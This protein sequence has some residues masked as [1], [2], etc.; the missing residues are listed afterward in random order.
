MKAHLTVVL[1]TTVFFTVIEGP[2]TAFELTE[3][4]YRAQAEWR[5]M[6]DDLISKGE[7]EVTTYPNP[8]GND[9]P[10]YIF[11]GEHVKDMLL[12][13]ALKML[14]NWNIVAQDQKHN[15]F[16]LNIGGDDYI[17][18]LQ[19]DRNDQIMVYDKN[20]IPPVYDDMF[21]YF[22]S[23]EVLKITHQD[24]IARQM[25]EATRQKLG[26]QTPFSFKNAEKLKK[27]MRDLM[28]VGQIAEPATMKEEM[29]NFL[30]EQY[31][32]IEEYRFETEA[33]YW[34]KASD[35]RFNQENREIYD[36]SENYKELFDLSEELRQASPD[37]VDELKDKISKAL[38]EPSEAFYE[39]LKDAK[40][41]EEIEEVVE[42]LGVEELTDAQYDEIKEAVDI[43]SSDTASDEEIANAKKQ[44]VNNLPELTEEYY[45]EL[46]TSSE[47]NARKAEFAAR[48][49]W[50]KLVVDT[51]MKDGEKIKKSGRVP[52]QD[53]IFRQTID[54]IA[55]NPKLS[56]KEAFTEIFPIH[57]KGG[58]AKA[59]KRL[60][61]EDY[62]LG[63]EVNEED[64]RRKKFKD[65]KAAA[66]GKGDTDT[67]DD[68]IA[69]ASGGCGV[70]SQQT[71]SRTCE[72]KQ[73][74]LIEDSFDWEDDILT[75]ETI[76]EDGIRVKNEI[77]LKMEDMSLPKYAKESLASLEEMGVK[78]EDSSPTPPEGGGSDVVNKGMGIYGSFVSLLSSAKFLQKGDYGQAAFSALQAVYSLGGLTGFNKVIEEVSSKAFAKM[79]GYTADKIGVEKAMEKMMELATKAV[80]ETAARVLDR[81]AGTLP[82]IGIAFD[83]Y[84]VAEDI[85]DLADKNSDTPFGLKIAHLVLDTAIM[86]LSVVESLV[87]EAAPFTEPFIIALTM[88]RIGIDDFYMDIKQ[89]LSQA[90]GK[91]FGDK[92]LA[93]FKGYEEGIVDVFTLG[94][95]TQ[96]ES[97]EQQVAFDQELLNNMTDPEKYFNYRFNN[98]QGDLDFTSGVVSQYGGF[99]NVKMHNNGSV[100]MIM[101]EVPNEDGL[102]ETIVKTFDFPYPVGDIVLGV[103]EVDLPV[104]MQETAYLWMFIPI[105]SDDVIADLDQH[106]SS[107]YGVYTGD[108]RN[109]TFYAL[110]FQPDP[111]PIIIKNRALASAKHSLD[112]DKQKAVERNAGFEEVF[113]QAFNQPSPWKNIVKRSRKLSQLS[114]YTSMD[115]KSLLTASQYNS[116]EC[117]DPNASSNISIYLKSYN[118]NLYG[119]GGDDKFFL[120]PQQTVVSGGEGEDLYYIQPT[121]GKTIID[122]FAIDE[123]IDTLYF[124]VSYDSIRCTRDNW[125]LL[126]GFC[127]THNVR[128]K[129]WFNHENDEF[130][131]HIQMVSK[132]GILMEPTSAEVDGD[133]YSISCDAVVVDRTGSTEGQTLILTGRFE[134]VKDVYGSNYSDTIIGNGLGNL[135]NAGMGDDKLEGGGGK[136]VYIIDEKDGNDI[137]NNFASDYE[138]DT[139]VFSV[140]YIRIKSEIDGSDLILSDSSTPSHSLRLDRWFSN[141]V[142]QHAVFLSKD[143]VQFTVELD[144]SGDPLLVAL[145]IDLGDYDKPVVIDLNNSRN[146]YNYEISQETS[147]D[148]KVIF[149]SKFDDRLV[150]NA[151]GNFFTCTGGNDMLRGNAGKDTYVA[152]TECSSMTID[153]YDDIKDIDLLLIRCQHEQLSLYNA[154]N[155]NKLIVEC[156]K[157]G[158]YFQ[159]IELINWFGGPNYQH[160]FIKTDDLITSFPP[161]N[162]TEYENWNGKLIP[163]E[164]QRKDQC[165]D[166]EIVEINLSLPDYNRVERVEIANDTCSYVIR[167]NAKSNYIDPGPG[168]P[169]H[170]QNLEG[171]NG[172]DVY[173]LGHRYGILN[174]IYNFAEDNQTDHLKFQVIYDDIVVQREEDDIVISSKSM[175]DSIQAVVI[176]YFKGSL[177]QHIVVETADNYMFRF[178]AEFPYTEVIMIDLSSSEYS[179]TISPH[180]NTTFKDAIILIGS[181]T[182]S[183]HIVGG[184]YSEIIIAGNASDTIYGGP[185]VEDLVGAES[186]D[187]IRGGDGD[188]G[189]Y[190]GDGEDLLFG[191]EGD[192]SFFGDL[193]SDV[194]DGG[195]GS[196]FIVFSGVNR[197]GV[198]VTL[199][200]GI[201]L[202]A[203]ATD[204]IYKSIEN[205]LGSEFDDILI[206]NDDNNIIRGYAGRDTLFPYGGFDLLHGGVGSD[207]Y[208]LEEASGPK[209]INNF[210]TDEALDM[211]SLKNYTSDRMCFFYLEEDLIMDISFNVN[212]Q[213]SIGRVMAAENF[214][215][216]TV[217][218]ALKNTTYQHL[219]FFFSDIHMYIEE[220]VEE[221]NQ[222]GAIYNQVYGG[223]FLH[224]NCTDESQICVQVNFTVIEI[225]D[226]PPEKY[227]LEL[228]QVGNNK[229]TYYPLSYIYT[230]GLE[231][232]VLK[233]LPSG[234]EQTFFASLSSCGLSVTYS[235]LISAVTIPNPPVNLIVD[236]VAFDGFT[237]HWEPPSIDTDPLIGNYSYVVKVILEETN[238]YSEHETEDISF[239]TS[240]VLPQ[241]EYK[242]LVY[243]KSYNTSSRHAA[244]LHLTTDNHTCNNLGDLPENLYILNFDRNEDDKLIANLSCIKGYRLHGDPIVICDEPNTVFPTCESLACYIPTLGNA[245][246]LTEDFDNDTNRP[247][248]GNLLEWKCNS[249]FEV[250]INVTTF[251]STCMDHSWKPSPAKCKLKLKCVVYPPQDGS[252]STD[253]IYVGENVTY[254]CNHGYA[255]VGPMTR[256]CARTYYGNIYWIPSYIPTCEHTH[257]PSLVPQAH[258]SYSKPPPYYE[259]TVVVLK[260]NFGYMVSNRYYYP[261]LGEYM[262]VNENWNNTVYLCQS[263]VVTDSFIIEK[264]QALQAKFRWSFTAWNGV[265]MGTNYY[266]H[267]CRQIGGIDFHFILP[268]GMVQC[269]RSFH[270]ENGPS[271]YE[272]ILAVGDQERFG[273]VSYVCI[274]STSVAEEI[275]DALGHSS[276][277]AS[278]YRSTA[279]STSKTLVGNSIN[280]NLTNTAKS[281]TERISCRARCD[282]LYLLNGE[283][284]CNQDRPM[285][286]DKCTFACKN[287]YYLI[288][289]KERQC[290]ANGWTGTHTFC[291]GKSAYF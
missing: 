56:F 18:R 213:D 23:S 37:E 156:V 193:G 162:K 202:N 214:L 184:F 82:F 16:Q 181:K 260:C 152:D 121:G 207:L 284:N 153:N 2:L 226:A 96:L 278:I 73:M 109:N 123:G 50:E 196:D 281:C 115:Q 275:C 13:D 1:L 139:I 11:N 272:G 199:Q 42:N 28:V 164:I 124:N 220:F 189:I 130:Y 271:V 205:I 206:G 9:F 22:S 83:L 98:S 204:D 102:P 39:G 223:Y 229:S 269:R 133:E 132:D 5:D 59:R 95:F 29:F 55:N 240:S 92:V 241:T 101:A 112:L 195:N 80:G 49:A 236:A 178:K 211:V 110:Q 264:I 174:K 192:D 91:N 283:V 242:I 27:T 100:T 168:N 246:L 117:D 105:K 180:E 201:G 8:N 145:T 239:T 194:I 48:K 212:N 230:G 38:P 250:A 68:A 216:I 146:N 74:K 67:V 277:S 138:L 76:D 149:D 71:P 126:I 222:I 200:A 166:S 235:P 87:P 7:I 81:L 136:D 221:G 135:I 167:G 20:N 34:Q 94:L 103:G 274:D 187:Y 77:E 210:A 15:V 215:E 45:N 40:D 183:N 137:I 131:R 158:E 161:A 188:D 107:R 259:D 10:M 208:M 289:D 225:A 175:N 60:Y 157:E 4:S 52:G 33:N 69:G 266:A 44:I 108:N 122:N 237:I 270:L 111:D 19:K 150:G 267:G 125:D 78:R 89:E 106:G 171:G 147:A 129:N 143:Y 159:I 118:Y 276:Y 219:I 185:G 288:G 232:I 128:V 12:S 93:F 54:A 32:K 209:V 169:F 245:T 248:E 3:K 233:N 25:L 191:D 62:D 257:C 99:L 268:G 57:L 179:Q 253:D 186:N 14:Q 234:V 46:T 231:T 127:D 65:I 273:S 243:S 291:D 148:V 258:G 97:L 134:H 285:E 249:R 254:H 17:F 280:G 31:A 251:N 116:E 155:S 36:K 198:M 75:F 86:R 30:K 227:T 24:E 244:G 79:M 51:Y 163:I 218:L 35:K 228:V 172:T 177:Y 119:E 282:P 47:A 224:T 53:H 247:L 252:I 114:P 286:G 170:Y 63:E 154:P 72:R 176:D 64:Q 21:E 256:Q 151:L 238:E 58:T 140:D 104:Y 43:L 144:N 165:H 61:G 141:S 190:G 265:S 6:W 160:L 279:F 182:A 217:A 85:K 290:T 173:V 287:G 197:T 90:K 255:L 88:I 263:M 203:D 261:D 84:F 41:R 66:A 120:G 262:C 70:A 113:D 142:F 26:D